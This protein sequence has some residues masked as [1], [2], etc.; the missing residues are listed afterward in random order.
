MTDSRPMIRFPL[1]PLVFSAAIML[2][3]APEA[4]GQQQIGVD[5]YGSQAATV[6][7]LAVPFPGAGSEVST[8]VLDRGF[9]QPLLRDLV[10]S[11][12]FSL[13]A[14]PPGTVVEGET[15]RRA[16]A[17]ALLRLESELDS[18]GEFVIEARLYD[19]GSDAIQMG[20]RYRGRSSALARIAHTLAND[21]VRHFNGTRGLFLSNIAFV[22]DRTGEREIWLMDYD[23]ASQL[24]ITSHRSMTLNPSFS[25]DGER[26]AYTAFSNDTSDLY[27][28][29]RRGGGRIKLSTGLNLNTSPVFSPDGKTIAFVGSVRGN[30]DIYLIDD[31]GRNLRRITSGGSIE[32]TPA[33]SPTGRQI[34]FT[35]GRSG[36]PQIYVMDAEGTNTRRVSFEGSWNDD[37]VFAP[38]GEVLAYTSRVNGR[39]QIR[40]MNLVT[41]ES[42]LLAGEGSNEQP[43]W[44]PDGRWIVFM[45]N[46]SGRWQIYRIAV[47]G[48]G[49]TQL[50][51]E[52]ENWSPD[53]VD[54][55]D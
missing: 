12:F 8:P 21:L 43:A 41:G 30:P 51:F 50:T 5:I 11:G 37:A 46:R 54:R 25:P 32:S 20:R 35:S 52:G 2:V 40:L 36:S 10:F 7:R 16:G 22:S 23:G 1:L 48:R 45:S 34:A 49:L 9:Y 26:L 15:A 53:W 29:H 17:Q 47:D 13:V 28:V 39:F 33:W 18:T 44:S 4:R 55:T 38:G 31:D 19:L 27:I 3:S 6:I 42:R 24:R 14:L